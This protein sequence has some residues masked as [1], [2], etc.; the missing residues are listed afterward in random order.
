MR[1]MPSVADWASYLARYH[2]ERP[3]ITEE[4]LAPATDE[5]GRSPYD[6]LLEPVRAA[7]DGFLVDVGCG[8]APVAR[9]LGRDHRYVGVDRS[10]AELRRGRAAAPVTVALGDARALPVADCTVDAV[11]ASMML[12]VVADVADVLAEARRVLR[13]GGRL[14]A[15]VPTRPEDDDPSTG[16][17]AEVLAALGQRGVRYPGSLDPSRLAAS[18]LDLVE[19]VAGRF[20]R[21][22][23]PEHCKLVVDSFYAIGA[24]DEQ[25][26]EALARLQARAAAG[27]LSVT[28]PLRRLVAVRSRR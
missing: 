8:S 24:S 20:T 19:D 11:V 15:T 22:V 28:Y 27:P 14:V 4:V 7:G 5:A 13:P 9:R 25:V 3:G 21:M 2:R 18:G 6:W 26:A 1:A 12:M 17:F 23:G 10:E 16:L